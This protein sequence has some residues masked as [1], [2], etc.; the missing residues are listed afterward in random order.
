MKMK[1]RIRER[2]KVEM[3]MRDCTFKPNIS[4][5]LRK[6]KSPM[7]YPDARTNIETASNDD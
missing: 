6:S 3:E 2:K 4:T 1:S 7:H 5:K